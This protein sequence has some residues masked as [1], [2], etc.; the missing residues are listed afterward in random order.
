MR[1]NVLPLCG[2][3]L[4]LASCG[5]GDDDYKAM[6]TFEAKEVI[7]SAAT[8]GK[9]LQLNVEEGTEVKA[10]EVGAQIDTMQLY[11]KKKQLEAQVRAILSHSPD[12]ST[13]IAAIQEQL[14]IAGDEKLRMENLVHA[15]VAPQ[16]QLD[17]M[18]A[19]IAVLEKQLT[20]Q[21][22]ALQT[23]G[24]AIC[25]EVEPVTL[26]IAQVNDQLNQSTLLH[27]ING[28][29]LVKYVEA[30]EYAMPGTALYKIADLSNMRLR[31]FVTGE[32]LSEIA[33]GSKVTV[34]TDAGDGKRKEW[35]G[36]IRSISEKAEFTPKTIMTSDE[37]SNLVYAV[38]IEVPNNGALKIGMYGE[39]NW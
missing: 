10:N 20:A 14:R 5:N 23:S 8:P 33:L 1:N 17:D 18:V 3:A 9:I 36:T 19:Q 6:G 7:V 21:R 31:A 35:T 15:G 38:L 30:G 16:K 28:T 22:S 11:L 2:L 32:Q 39:V 34:T 27:P 25:A 4:L 12:V 24:N 29:I 26:Q 13:Q 37:R